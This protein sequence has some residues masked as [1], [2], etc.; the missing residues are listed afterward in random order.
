MVVRG[1]VEANVGVCLANSVS[2]NSVT[3]EFL[4]SE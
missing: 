2:Q 3:L 4:A 1:D